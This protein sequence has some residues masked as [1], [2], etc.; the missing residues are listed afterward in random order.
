MKK[1]FPKKFTPYFENDST[2]LVNG[3]SFEI[4]KK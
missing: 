1:V 2:V 3:D 4:L